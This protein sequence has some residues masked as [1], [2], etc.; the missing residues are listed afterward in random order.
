M[1]NWIRSGCGSTYQKWF[2]VYTRVGRGKRSRFG[3]MH[4]G[5]NQ[6]LGHVQ[7]IDVQCPPCVHYQGGGDH[8][9]SIVA[10]VRVLQCSFHARLECWGQCCR[11]NPT[12]SLDVHDVACFIRPRALSKKKRRNQQPCLNTHRGHES[13]PPPPPPQRELH[14]RLRTW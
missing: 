9:V 10:H 1:G 5:G 7:T 12:H 11:L 3:I 13:P 4:R 2:N 14:A 6:T 8:L